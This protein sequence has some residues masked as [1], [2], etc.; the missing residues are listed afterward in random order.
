MLSDIREYFKEI[1]INLSDKIFLENIFVSCVIIFELFNINKHFV[2]SWLVTFIIVILKIKR[3]KL[4]DTVFTYNLY[5]YRH[6]KNFR[7]FGTLNVTLFILYILFSYVVA[8][9]S[10]FILTYFIKKG[11]VWWFKIDSF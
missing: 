10:V 11:V 5:K 1:F 9:I 8:F 4:L 7:L 2:V 3:K 6:F